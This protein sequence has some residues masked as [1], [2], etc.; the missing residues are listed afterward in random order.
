MLTVLKSRSS[1]SRT[2]A[3]EPV[4]Q[5]S[6]Y[7]GAYGSTNIDQDPWQDQLRMFYDD[8]A[9]ALGLLGEIVDFY[10]NGVALYT[11]GVGIRDM[12]GQYVPTDDPGLEKV[13]SEWRDADTGMQA[14]LIKEMERARL[15]QGEQVHLRR[16]VGNSMRYQV[17]HPPQI[18]SQHRYVDENGDAWLPVRYRIATEMPR[19]GVT[20]PGEIE[21]HPEAEMA[22]VWCKGVPY[23]GEAT[24]SLKRILRWLHRLD[25][26][27][28]KMF[29]SID[30][31][32][33]INKMLLLET[34]E[35]QRSKTA[36]D[37]FVDDYL[38]A[39]ELSRRDG[40]GSWASAPFVGRVNNPSSA[41]LL[42]LGGDITR[43]DIEA[44]RWLTEMIA[45]SVSIPAAALLEG[46]L[47]NRWSDWLLDRQ[48]Q[49]RAFQPEVNE[50]TI[51][52]TRVYLHPTMRDLQDLGLFREYTIEDLRIIG[53][54][55]PPSLEGQPDLVMKAWQLGLIDIDEAERLMGTQAPE[56][57]T[58]GYEHWLI[59]AKLAGPAASAELQEN[60][61]DEVVEQIGT[62]GD[63]TQLN[64]PTGRPSEELASAGSSWWT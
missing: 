35:G 53:K 10:S 43:M 1:K 33:M 51:E 9:R 20:I 60:T 30:S 18:E 63:G 50:L 42:D 26:L 39:A 12:G 8:P 22:R 23:T 49:K 58:D 34:N 5:T 32:L 61:T 2:A 15:L 57:G 3:V 46:N 48:V 47:S 62:D 13:A 11:L 24:S 4:R 25:E 17:I 31:R 7:S 28:R 40:Q 44:M 19:K 14:P 56:V 45:Q 54:P 16:K 38:K 29:R 21:W 64:A 27:D 59:A 36:T 6:S 41:Q 52:A 37:D 55:P